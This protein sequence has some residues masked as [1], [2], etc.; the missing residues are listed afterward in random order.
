MGKFFQ[1]LANAVARH[2]AWVLS[3]LVFV[4]LVAA[5]FYYA[6]PGAAH[7]AAASA[8]TLGPDDPTVRKL[9]VE[10][11]ALEKTYH[12]AT[13]GGTTLPAALD[14]LDQAVQKQRLLVRL[15]AGADDRQTEHLHRLETERENLRVQDKLTRILRLQA[16]G[17]AALAADHLAEAD[18]PLH[19]A[20]RLQR[21]V[22]ASAAAASNKSLPRETALRQL[23]A[24]IEVEPVNQDLVA[25]LNQARAA[26]AAGRA[27]EALAAFN[28]ART[29]Q[30]RLNRDYPG[31]P[32]ADVTAPQK[33][34][35]EIDSLGAAGLR[36]E[37]EAA[38]RAG[39]AALAAGHAGEA[40]DAF[41]LAH[42]RQLE[43]NKRFPLGEFTS[44]TRADALEIRRQTAASGPVA[45]LL[46]TLD[47]AIAEAAR[48]RQP[49]VAAQKIAE[50]ARTAERLFSAFPLSPRLDPAL[51]AKVD[52]LA[53]RRGDLVEI[54]RLSHASLLPLPGAP[55]RALLKTEVTQAL[56]SLVTGGNPSRT[57]APA[58]PVDSVSW[59][60]ARTFC[61]QLSWLL[62]VP[63]RLPTEAEFRAALGPGPQPVAWGRENSS[64]AT[65]PAAK[66]PA[67]AAGFSDLLGNVA[68]WLD[69]D[70]TAEDAPIAG[71][72]Y[73]D[74]AAVL[75]KVPVEP[76]AKNDRARFIGFRIVVETAGLPPAGPGATPAMLNS[77]GEALPTTP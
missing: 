36:A 53:A 16:E 29:L 44:A 34:A 32:Y 71:G 1:A 59:R 27:P 63:V 49:A 70:D 15:T 65:Q 64:G 68:E 69:A 19:E 67:N 47:H 35:A 6:G 60:E 39:E 74:N 14:A 57:P 25:A 30:G 43:I 38:E 77:A 50:A 21:E 9:A 46:V 24:R 22:N 13:A 11:A 5:N 31:T 33:I 66:Q 58:R 17:E 10:V 40:A 45:D 54:H 3:L 8:E 61:T 73:Q 55:G 12:D 41:Q 48:Q 72:S 56:Y 37:S 42:A 23:V 7:P 75:A 28:R 18:Q 20:L 62:G 4:G 2:W 76:R 52:Y 26:A 51:K